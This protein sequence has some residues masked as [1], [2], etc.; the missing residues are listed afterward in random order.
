M[1]NLI[2]KDTVK[3]VD[4]MCQSSNAVFNEFKIPT[5]FSI[6][7]GNI[8]VRKVNESGLLDMDECVTKE[9]FAQWKKDV[10][11]L[12]SKDFNKGIFTGYFEIKAN[13]KRALL[14]RI[15]YKDLIEMKESGFN[16][17]SLGDYWYTI[18][19][20]IPIDGNYND[21]DVLAESNL[22]TYDYSSASEYTEK[23][24]VNVFFDENQDQ[25]SFALFDDPIKESRKDTN[26]LDDPDDIEEEEIS[27][28]PDEI[29]EFN[30]FDEDSYDE[31]TPEE[32]IENIEIEE[33]DEDF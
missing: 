9:L 7:F 17:I 18:M 13:N 28:F 24:K 6:R 25:Q 3:E 8:I 32:F 33:T 11:R 14:R 4:E 1:K 30:E 19:R 15:E 5:G 16:H 20:L 12:M 10:G 26:T 22:V 31:P 23:D 2:T 21:A 27:A 29:P